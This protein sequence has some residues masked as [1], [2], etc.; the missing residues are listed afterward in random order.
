MSDKILINEGKKVIV[1]RFGDALNK[2]IQLNPGCKAAVP[3]G[4][5]NNLLK[6]YLNTFKDLNFCKEGV[7]QNEDQQESNTT[8]SQEA[9]ENNQQPSG[10][11]E[12]V[13]G[14]DTGAGEANQ[15]IDGQQGENDEDASGDGDNSGEVDQDDGQGESDQSGDDG[16]STP[17]STDG[18][19]STVE[20]FTKKEL[21]KLNAE[22]VKELAAKLGIEVSED[23]T[24]KA[25]VAVI[26][27]KQG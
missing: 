21:E 20:K 9:P 7:D 22:Q 26:L 11:D 23:S 14:E 12:Q 8:I 27:E 4:M 19:E 16:Q 10:N 25:L 2:K 6:Y 17:D 15:Q 3:R 5:S 13:D 18:D 24:K 1:L